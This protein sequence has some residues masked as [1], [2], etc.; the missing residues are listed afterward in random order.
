MKQK[1]VNKAAASRVGRDQLGFAADRRLDR[2]HCQR[3][4]A[5]ETRTDGCRR[6]SAQLDL[7]TRLGA[8]IPSAG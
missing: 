2:Q 4:F 5:I 7:V 6:F 3:G 8:D 1:T